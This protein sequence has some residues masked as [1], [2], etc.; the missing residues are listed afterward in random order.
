MLLYH[1]CRP[2]YSTFPLFFPKEK[3]EMEMKTVKFSGSDSV[4]GF[5]DLENV[6]IEPKI[7]SKS[8]SVADTSLFEGF[9][10]SPPSL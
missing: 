7:M 9:Q 10:L 8:C 1:V 5:S 4:I 2:I 3:P 6:G